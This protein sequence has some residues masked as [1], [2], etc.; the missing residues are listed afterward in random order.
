MIS[1]IKPHYEDYAT[2]YKTGHLV[3]LTI[4]VLYIQLFSGQFYLVEQSSS[5][6]F[7]ASQHC[8]LVKLIGY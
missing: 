7:E 8:S 5:Q 1:S 2:I 3:I 6:H 4:S